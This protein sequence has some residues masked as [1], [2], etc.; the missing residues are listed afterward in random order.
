[1]AT[2]TGQAYAD[3]VVLEPGGEIEGPDTSVPSLR[4]ELRLAPGEAREMSLPVS[5]AGV[6]TVADVLFRCGGDELVEELQQALAN[7]FRSRASGER[8][9]AHSELAS[10][11]LRMFES[12]RRELRQDA[13]NALVAVDASVRRVFEHDLTLAAVELHPRKFGLVLAKDQTATV[14]TEAAALATYR[15]LRTTIADLDAKRRLVR[16]WSFTIPPNAPAA[17]RQFERDVLAP[18]CDALKAAGKTWP[19]M[20]VLGSKVVNALASERRNDVQRWASEAGNDTRLDQVIRE[21]LVE[22][23]TDLLKEQPA[24]REAIIAAAD[25]AMASAQRQIQRYWEEPP[26]ATVGR[27]HPLWQHGFVVQAALEQQGLAPGDIGHAA[28]TAGLRVAANAQERKASESAETDRM[29][30]WASLGFGVLTLVPVVGQL[31]LLAV[32]TVTAVQALEHAQTYLQQSEQSRAL[33]HQAHRYAVADP[34]ATALIC[35]LLSLTSDIALPVLGK[36]LGATVLRPT[37][38]VLAA[39]RVRRVLNLGERSADLAGI[40]ADANAAATE[41][42]LRRLGLLTTE[43]GRP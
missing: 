34:D 40:V 16:D 1:M 33:G 35:D 9:F 23:Y 26:E 6:G 5:Q 12:A 42:E 30:G 39:A 25:A 36:A 14:S 19:A 24:Y 28:A 22:A 10:E 7:T 31:A 2:Q 4:L 11:A 32:L 3:F 29:L 20:E 38:R 41:R 18:Y 43:T 21:T 17:R 8:E 13:F 15:Q 37:S 27:T